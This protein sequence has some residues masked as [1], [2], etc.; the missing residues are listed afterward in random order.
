MPDINLLRDTPGDDSQK[1]KNQKP[2]N[3]SYTNP[4]IKPKEKES[5]PKLKGSFLGGLF[6]RRPKEPKP[7]RP[8]QTESEDYRT[9]SQL[10]NLEPPRPAEPAG[11]EAPLTAPVNP[12]MRKSKKNEITE[13][14][15]LEEKVEKKQKK[16]KKR[17]TA[18]HPEMIQEETPPF[19][20]VNLM[21][22]D[23]I[24]SLEPKKKLIIYAIVIVSSVLLVGLIYLGLN[25][26]ENN[27]IEDVEDIGQQINEV[28]DDI[29]SL[30]SAQKQALLLKSQTD[31]IHEVLDNQ[32]H[33]SNFF[34]ML[35]K[36]TINEVQYQNFAGS[37]SRGSN[38]TFTL[39]A[40]GNTYTSVARQIMAFRDEA[41][42]FVVSVVVNQAGLVKSETGENNYINF[43]I[44]LVV[45]EEVFYNLPEE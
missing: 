29:A 31:H 32:V 24:E 16:E 43:P 1:K 44:Q 28:E 30:R 39:N 11:R 13:S 27:I 14:Q 19:L 15:F 23:L 2:G 7:A 26:Y 22:G 9:N 41:K 36:Y 17:K 33:W 42:D 34:E 6:R 10:T 12:T 35:E 20:D 38:P 4:E 25:Y 37:F 8:T 3:F 40:V 21:P 45:R 18:S 5:K